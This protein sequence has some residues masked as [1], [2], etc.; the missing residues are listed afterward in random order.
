MAK[1]FTPEVKQV[2]LKP[3][4]ARFVALM[5]SQF[6]TD[7]K[8]TDGHDWNDEAKK[9]RGQMLA[10]ATSLKSKLTKLGFNV[11]DLDPYQEGDENEFLNR[12]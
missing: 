8:E 5:T 2:F 12:K 3:D 4:E 11:D 1:Q 6:I 9:Y 10:A 7:H